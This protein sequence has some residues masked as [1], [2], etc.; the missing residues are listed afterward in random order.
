MKGKKTWVE[1]ELD[2]RTYDLLM[3]AAKE[4]DKTPDEIV[5]EAMRQ[6]L[7]KEGVDV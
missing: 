4:Q 1:L 2:D 7:R 3:K 6:G 5:E